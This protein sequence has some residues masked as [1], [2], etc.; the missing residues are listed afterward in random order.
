MSIVF[1]TPGNFYL[2]VMIF[3]SSCYKKNQDICFI[4]ILAPEFE[5]KLHNAIKETIFQANKLPIQ[6]AVNFVRQ[7]NENNKKKT[8]FVTC[9]GTQNKNKN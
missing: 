3:L 8:H 9:M 7:V 6:I 1:L 2:D 5:R 4:K